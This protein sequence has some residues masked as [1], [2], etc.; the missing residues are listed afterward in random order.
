MR[1]TASKL[2][3]KSRVMP[4]IRAKRLER[5]QMPIND[6]KSPPVRRVVIFSDEKNW[7][8]DPVRNR[9]NDRYLFLREEDESA[10]TLSKTKHQT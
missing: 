2:G 10:H 1:R 4:A 9:R 6:P 3:I 5:C 7:T 8:V